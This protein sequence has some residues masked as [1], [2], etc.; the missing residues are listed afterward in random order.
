ME[1]TWIDLVHISMYNLTL[2]SIKKYHDIDSVISHFIIENWENF[3][4][5]EKVYCQN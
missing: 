5:P 4:L 3:N 1:L 2:V